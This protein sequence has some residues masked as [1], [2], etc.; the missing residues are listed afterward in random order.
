M[1]IVNVFML[2]TVVKN[3]VQPM[4]VLESTVYLAELSFNLYPNLG[5]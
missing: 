2:V 3:Y 5:K 4:H 1:Y